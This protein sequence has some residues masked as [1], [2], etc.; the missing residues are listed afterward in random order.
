MSPENHHSLERQSLNHLCRLLVFCN[1]TE[2]DAPRTRIAIVGGGLAGATL[3][4]GLFQLPHLDVHVF[5]SAPTFSER[6]ASVGLASNAKEALEHVIPGQVNDLLARAGGVA[7]NSSRCLIGSGPH[8]GEVVMDL[9]GTDP[10]TCVHRAALLRELVRP[11]PPERLHTNKKLSSINATESSGSLDLIFNDGTTAQTDAVIGADGIFGSVRSYVLQDQA[12]EFSASPA[13]FWDSRNLVSW[14]QARDVLGEEHFHVDRQVGW[15]GEGAFIMHDVLDDRTTVACVISALE[16]SPPKE[17]KRALTK[18]FLSQT[19]AGWLDGPIATGMIE[20]SLDQDQPYA[21]SEW[22]HKATPTYSHGRT[23]IMGDAAHAST[24]WQGSGAAMAFEDAM[25][26]QE[27]LKNVNCA[28]DISLAFKAYDTLR[29]PRCQRIIDS[30]RETGM[31]LCG[32]NADVGLNPEKLREALAP[33]WQFIMDLDMN[34]H[35]EEAL[36]SFKALQS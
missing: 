34:A 17:R 7:I 36:K 26:L 1:M 15:A 9:A 35:K 11:L 6:G 23:C 4:N 32:Q 16:T 29:R 14:A 25:V 33:R 19:L 2:Q 8:A 10:G 18:D 30:S 27:L 5:E 13:G 20:L 22:E 31:I 21:Y 24:P 3:A 28:A 12:D